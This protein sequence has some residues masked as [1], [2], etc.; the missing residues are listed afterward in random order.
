VMEIECRGPKIRITLNGQTI[1]DVDQST[2]A[3]IKNKP[4][5]GYLC[6]QNHGKLIEFRNVRVKGL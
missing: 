4:L 1:Q 6:L 2:I 5:S 3:E